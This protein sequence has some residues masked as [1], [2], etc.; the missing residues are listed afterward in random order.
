MHDICQAL[1]KIVE[2]RVQEPERW[3]PFVGTD[4]VEV[5]NDGGPYGRGGAID[6]LV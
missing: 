5:C 3:L 1:L 2:P 6:K 4:T